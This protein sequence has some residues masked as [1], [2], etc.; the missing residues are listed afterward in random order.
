VKYRISNH[1]ISHAVVVVGSVGSVGSVAHGDLAAG[2]VAHGDLAADAAVGV[3]AAVTG[4][5][6]VEDSA[7]CA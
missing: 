1:L 7:E 6:A 3:V 4:V 2:L 5:A